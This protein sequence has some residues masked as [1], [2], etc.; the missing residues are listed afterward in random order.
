M[1]SLQFLLSL[2][3]CPT[4]E[5]GEIDFSSFRSMKTPWRTFER[6]L[7]VMFA[8]PGMGPIDWTVTFFNY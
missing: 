7:T 1:K 8:F 2:P 3:A 5:N 6:L 4:N